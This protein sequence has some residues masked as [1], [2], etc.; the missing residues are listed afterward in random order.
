MKRSS[1]SR[2]PG[3]VARF[4]PV[5]AVAALI[6]LGSSISNFGGPRGVARF[7]LA[8]S[9]HI[10]EYALLALALLRAFRYW[11]SHHPARPAL[12]VGLLYAALDEVHQATVAGRH[13]SPIDVIVFDFAGLLLGLA[14][15]AWWRSRRLHAERS[16]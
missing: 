13:P 16:G 9:V 4:G 5:V 7:V 1:S 10:T 8:K 14:L 6:F 15:A 2:P 3:F 11:G 12:G